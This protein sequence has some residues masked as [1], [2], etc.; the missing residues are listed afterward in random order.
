M[1]KKMINNIEIH[2]LNIKIVSPFG[3]LYRKRLAL[4]AIIDL[5]GNILV[6]S[7][8]HFYPQDIYRLIGGGIDDNEEVI[9]GCLR[10]L[11][12]E[13]GIEAIK[14]D[15]KEIM[16]VNVNA[17]DKNGKEYKNTNYIFLYKLKTNNYKAGDDIKQII[18]L[19]VD[20]LY[21]L[22]ERYENLSSDDWFKNDMENYNWYDYGQVYGPIHK[23]V[24]SYIVKLK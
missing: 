7:K 4:I 16:Q 19:S 5:D 9:D 24:A 20:A 8:P 11:K 17:V 2:N 14:E 23:L 10:E 18:K 13:V 3:N 15:L 21:K 6:G 22:G 12:E 1:E